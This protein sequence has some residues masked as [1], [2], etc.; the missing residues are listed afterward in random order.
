MCRIAGGFAKDI[1]KKIYSMATAMKNG[2]DSEPNF[3]INENFAMSH[4]RLSIIDLSQNASQ[5]ARLDNLVLSFNGE[6]YNYKEIATELG[7][8]EKSDTRVILYAYKKWGIKCLDKFDGMFAFALYDSLSKELF[9]ARDRFG[10]K[11]LY[12]YYKDNKFI[13]VS[14]LKALFAYDDFDKT[15]SK[16][17]LSYFL[18]SG[19]TPPNQSIF[20]FVK[21]LPAG[22]YLKFK[23]KPEIFLYYD[24]KSKFLVQKS[25]DICNF[26]TKLTDSIISRTISDVGFCSFLSGG[27]D[28]SVTAAILAKNGF[29]FPTISIGFENENF[30]ESIYAKKVA[31]S[32]NLEH[33]SFTIT[34]KIAKDIILKLPKIYDEPFGDSSAIPTLFLCQRAKEFGKVA[35]SSDGGDELN[36][37]YIR[38]DLNYKR[39]KFYKKYSFL[40]FAFLNLSYSTL[41]SYFEA[42]GNKL[43]N[44][45]Y[46]RIKDSFNSKTF[47]DLYSL[48]FRHF[49]SDDTAILDLENEPNLNKYTL[50]DE[51][52][53]MSFA[54]ISSYL[55]DDIFVKTDRASMSVALEVREP[56]MSHKFIEHAL[57]IEPNLRKN[58]T[59]LKNI[60]RK[61]IPNKLI[62][63]PKMGFA[64][65]LQEWFYDDLGFLIDEYI[66]KSSE[67]NSN[68]VK[69]LIQNFRDKK[70]VNFSKIWNILVF[71]MWKKD[72]KI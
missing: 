40:K 33:Y 37:G 35:L 21:K 64:L 46:Q 50:Y 9:I 29:K 15:I 19:Y 59:L 16:T 22:C 3:Y 53:S 23:N 27:I 70:A 6:I 60:L 48:E 63:R 57:S 54:D 13:F 12:Y 14:E 44:D 31:S 25:K 47:M 30:D 34:P 67:F 56:L 1:N 2:G 58:K 26:E 32:L 62:D 36:F 4:N 42:F 66:L 68:Y 69:N 17:A 10:V 72:W 24:L 8:N 43:S 65:P 71:L 11:P 18:N 55:C 52:E 7:I 49:K 20:E 5:P 41:Q 38:Y 61:H 45:K 28:S 51:F 39:H